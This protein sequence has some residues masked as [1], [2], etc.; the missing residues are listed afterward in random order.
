MPGVAAIAPQQMKPISAG[1]LGARDRTWS[2]KGPSL[3]AGYGGRNGW[4]A[5][6]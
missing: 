1:A 5:E 3:E 6:V 4:T 2:A